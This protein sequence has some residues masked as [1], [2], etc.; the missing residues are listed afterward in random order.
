ML[1]NAMEGMIKIWNPNDVDNILNMVPW[2][3]LE[4]ENGWFAVRKWLWIKYVK[5][6]CSE[7]FWFSGFWGQN[8][9]CF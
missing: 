3:K 9:K 4:L 1:G 6:I 8:Q 5:E 7:Y 2:T